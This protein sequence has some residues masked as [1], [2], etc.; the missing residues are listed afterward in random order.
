T[1]GAIITS[2]K[3]I[4]G[5][6]EISRKNFISV[7]QGTSRF[8]TV[9]YPGQ[10]S[11]MT[12]RIFSTP[13]FENEK[14]AYIVQV[15]TPLTSIEAA[16]NN[17]KVTLFLLF[18]ITILVTGVMGSF[19]AKAAM[20]PVDNMIQTIHQITAENMKLRIASP[21]T[22]DEVQK[23]AET[24]NE[25]LERLEGAFTAQQQLFADL[26]HE[27]KTPLTILRGEFE[28]G[29]K[30]ARSA[31]EYEAILHS[32]LEEI[33]R[34]TKLA[35]SLLL[36]AKF[37]SKEVR[38]EMKLIDI[39]SLI[40]DSVNH[41]KVLSEIKHIHLILKAGERI[42]MNADEGQLKTA[43]LNLLDNAVKYTPESGNIDVTVERK[44]SMARITI[45]DS[46]VGIPKKEI[47]HIFDRFYRVEKSRNSSGFGLGLS[48][49][50]SI[51]E[52]HNGT[53]EVKSN[54][55]QGTA[56]IIKI[57]AL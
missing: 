32:G 23:L 54:A 37:D 5:L 17:L 44:M 4:H 1:D 2:S 34:I 50:R 16:L 39:S 7:L 25:M 30:R 45:H 28:V 53:I 9:V 55:S 38:P 43:F 41:I 11:D 27:L 8:D 40:Q 12:L 24:F 18:P 10:T 29:L 14:V 52:A 48:I 47:R 3:N 51:I 13:V 49:A 6:A 26:S 20:H 31:E 36:L 56:F 15:S 42:L 57:P 21:K 33:N 22:K 35:D 19:L 46:G